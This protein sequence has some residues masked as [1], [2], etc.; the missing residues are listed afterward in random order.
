[1]SDAEAEEL[2]K[3]TLE[4]GVESVEY[5]EGY[6]T[7]GQFF[8]TR[9]IASN[10]FGIAIDYNNF[11]LITTG[12][13]GQVKKRYFVPIDTEVTEDLLMASG[14]LAI[15][16]VQV[17]KYDL[18]ED[19]VGKYKD[20][21]QELINLINK[22]NKTTGNSLSVA[23]HGGYIKRY[24]ANLHESMYTT[25]KN[26]FLQEYAYVTLKREVTTSK[27]E[28]KLIDSHKYRVIS[29]DGDKLLLEYNIYNNY[30]Q[31]I[32]VN[33][34]ID[35]S[36]EEGKISRIY[37]M[38]AN[39]NLDKLKALDTKNKVKKEETVATR[40]EIAV[41]IIDTFK[42][43]YDI[44]IV[45]TAAVKPELAGKKAWI[46]AESTE[47][48]RKIVINTNFEDAREEVVHE[49]LHLFLMASRY[50][51]AEQNS[52]FYEN[53]MVTYLKSEQ[54]RLSGINLNT[55]KDADLI[56]YNAIMG[57]SLENL[58][59]VALEEIFVTDVN[60]AM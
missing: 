54:G 34:F 14:N 12:G 13:E 39:R 19:E 36:T 47:N 2:V 25:D 48:K 28:K 60:A 24:D 41:G 52:G 16:F 53:L 56:H 33:K 50:S 11:H 59:L 46:A 32:T 38:F 49:Y 15:G 21:T 6:P 29:R 8:T 31:V 1:M 43:L 26:K 4:N 10:N 27:G 37:L 45:T 9:N 7:D 42:E 44:T 23:E 57:L 55:L 35:L 3:Y 22:K 30:G 20:V 40:K 5:V 18:T 17:D 51:N 58:N